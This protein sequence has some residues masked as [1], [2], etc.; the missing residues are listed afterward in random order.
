MQITTLRKEHAVLVTKQ[1]ELEAAYRRFTIDECGM[2]EEHVVAK[3]EQARSAPQKSK[4]LQ[5]IHEAHAA[6][7]S[8]EAAIKE[9]ESAVAALGS[10]DTAPA[11]AQQ[12]QEKVCV[13]PSHSKLQRRRIPQSYY[14]LCKIVTPVRDRV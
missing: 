2:E 6:V 9:A 14:V 12:Q 3:I 13:S 10:A 11:M 5:A 1:Q 7:V 8:K 4:R